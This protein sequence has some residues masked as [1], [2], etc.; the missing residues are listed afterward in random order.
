MGEGYIVRRGGVGGTLGF[1]EYTYN[2]GDGS[3]TETRNETNKYWELKLLSSGDLTFTKLGNA[4][5]GI[6]VFLLGGGGAGANTGSTAVGGGGYYNTLIA[7]SVVKGTIYQAIIGAG[8]ESAG[9]AGGSS[10]FLG[11]TAQGGGAAIATSGDYTVNS[12]SGSNVNFYLT[13]TATTYDRVGN[14]AQTVRL[15]VENGDYVKPNAETNGRYP[16]WYK[17][18]E[19]F[20][21]F[22]PPIT[23]Q[24][25]YYTAGKGADQTQIFGTG[26]VV[27][28]PGETDDAS[29][30]GQGGGTSGIKG[31]DGIIVIRPAAVRITTQPADTT[32]TTDANAIFSVVAAGRKLKYQWQ[33]LPTGT[34]AQWSATTATGAN[35]NQLTIQALSYR[36]GYKYRCIVSDGYN[37]QVISNEATLTIFA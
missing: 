31:G 2:G 8:A 30:R 32:A 29:C 12:N 23:L 13:T 35:T 6:D 1:P 15:K 34:G 28:G 20:Y 26:D 16:G 10:S 3:F 37:N 19:G 21:T 18:R 7:R 36:N 24:K 4:S 27:S 5:G 17:G 22:N 25:L 11:E 33:F 9:N 14:G